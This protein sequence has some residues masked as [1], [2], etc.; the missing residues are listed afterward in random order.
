MSIEKYR[1]L[2]VKKLDNLIF[3]SGDIS[4]KCK[5]ICIKATCVCPQ[6]AGYNIYNEIKAHFIWLLYSLLTFTI[7][8][9]Q[10]V[11]KMV[12]QS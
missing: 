1:L 5:D 6:N 10:G 12:K 11:D 7:G 8:E 3:F 4:N 2:N 9:V